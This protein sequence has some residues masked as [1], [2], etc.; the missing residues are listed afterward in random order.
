MA[1]VPAKAAARL[2][3]GLK[4]FQ[5]ILEDAHK[6]D[7]NEA[8]TVT[9]VTDLLCELFGYDKYSELTSEHAVRSSFCDIAIK[10][11]GTLALLLE[12]KAI[13]MELKDAHVK[14]AVDY[15]ANEGC[16]WAAVTN[17]ILW[18]TY[19]LTFAK[20]IQADLVLELDLLQLNPRKT[21]DIESLAL[22]SREAWQKSQL[23]E[24]AVQRQALSR[25]T[26]AATLLSDPCL[27]ILRRELRRISP[28]I[29][30]AAEDIA[31]VLSHEVIKRE[32]LEGERAEAARKLV[33]KSARRALRT[34]D[35]DEEEAP[36]AAPG[37]SATPPIEAK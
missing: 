33:T 29:T 21:E 32:V 24:Y 34:T 8:D 26:I 1:T 25:F 6:R 11:E 3:I 19:R 16:E 12:V 9:I 10:L 17:G 5:P 27:G 35:K 4:K 37:G 23:D 22:L 2:T 28:D 7:V 15:A 31:R 13:G 18:R 20:P 30:I 36:P 14:Q